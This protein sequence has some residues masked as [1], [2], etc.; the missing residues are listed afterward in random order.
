M[1]IMSERSERI[2]WRNSIVLAN[3]RGDTVLE[4]A[5]TFLGRGD[6]LANSGRV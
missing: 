5:Y 3:L 4:K 2:L 6:A 1:P